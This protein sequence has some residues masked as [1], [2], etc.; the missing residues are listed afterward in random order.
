MAKQDRE[1]FRTEDSMKKRRICTALT[2]AALLILSGCGADAAANEQAKREE[3]PYPQ[4][5][6]VVSALE[7]AGFQVEQSDDFTELGISVTRIT[8]VNGEEYLDVCYDIASEDDRDKIVDYY[9]S[10]DSYRKYSLVSDEEIV[11]C[12]SSESVVESAGLQ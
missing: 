9:T 7:E 2:L 3:E 6:E 12:Y 8:A 10:E 1:N 4:A 5:A 11:Y